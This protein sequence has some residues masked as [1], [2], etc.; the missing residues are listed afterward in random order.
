LYYCIVTFSLSLPQAPDGF[1]GTYE[2]VLAHEKAHG[3]GTGH[4]TPG[5]VV[6]RPPVAPQHDR[7]LMRFYEAPDGFRGTY[8]DVLAHEAKLGMAKGNE[9]AAE[10]DAATI[11]H[12]YEVTRACQLFRFLQTKYAKQ[13]LD[14]ISLISNK[15]THTAGAGRFPRHL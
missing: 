11:M 6:S 5:L 3:M 7:V 14:C 15:C 12:L 9:Q 2:E 8:D 1:R 4:E 10:K 13:S